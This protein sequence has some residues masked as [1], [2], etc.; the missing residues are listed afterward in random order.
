M[1]MRT[2]VVEFF[3]GSQSFYS[4]DK[5]H[6]VNS[7]NSTIFYMNSSLCEFGVKTFNWAFSLY[8][9]VRVLSQIMC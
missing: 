3:M 7:V 4:G 8:K 9:G 2:G 5:I 1:E 6:T